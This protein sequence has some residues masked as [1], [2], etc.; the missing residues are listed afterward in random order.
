MILHAFDHFPMPH[1]A[2]M[3]STRRCRTSMKHGVHPLYSLLS[4][5][6]WLGLLACTCCAWSPGLPALCRRC[7]LLCHLHAQL[8]VSTQ[9]MCNAVQ[10]WCHMVHHR[11]GM[12]SWS[13]MAGH[14]LPPWLQC[15]DGIVT[16]G[17]CHGLTFCLAP[18]RA[19]CVWSMAFTAKAL[20]LSV[21]LVFC[22]ACIR[23]TARLRALFKVCAGPLHAYAF[24]MPASV[25]EATAEAM[26]RGCHAH[27][28]VHFTARKGVQ[29]WQD[30]QAYLGGWLIFPSS[31][32]WR[33]R[34]HTLHR[35]AVAELRNFEFLWPA[36]EDDV[37]Y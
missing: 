33:R 12:C 20:A 2:C 36:R 34:L 17:D 3:Y 30:V 7:C 32:A 31:S 9:L 10:A 25:F 16:C 37:L 14:G 8:G 6:G 23:A 27:F 28:Y 18:S 35:H 1:M 15:Q 13:S 5:K 21:K 22:P 11:M 4:W 26:L 29:N 19:V 24:T